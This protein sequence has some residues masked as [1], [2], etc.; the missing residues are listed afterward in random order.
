MFRKTVSLFVVLTWSL[1]NVTPVIADGEP[2]VTPDGDPWDPYGVA[3]PVQDLAVDS[4]GPGLVSSVVLR[5]WSLQ[6][7]AR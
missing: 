5:L 6:W 7:V 3:Q 4:S 2:D 1:I